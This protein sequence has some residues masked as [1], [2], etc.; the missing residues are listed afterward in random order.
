MFTIFQTSRTCLSVKP[1]YW[2][3]CWINEAGALSIQVGPFVFE[4][5]TLHDYQ[6]KIIDRVAAGDAVLNVHKDMG[7][8]KAIELFLCNGKLHRVG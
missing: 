8:T 3:L 1:L 2:G 4:R 5:W 7:K 6:R